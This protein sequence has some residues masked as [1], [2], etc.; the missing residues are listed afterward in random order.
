[1]AGTNR[2]KHV[3]HDGPVVILVEPQLMENVGAAARAMANFGLSEM[4]I[5]NPRE[6]FPSETATTFAAGAG[7]VLEAARV[8]ATVE[9]AISDLGFI[10]AATARERGQAK[11]VAGPEAVMRDAAAAIA[12]GARAGIMFG[13]ER[14]GL[15]NAE[16][17]LADVIM[18]FAVNPAYASLN[19]AQA[20]LLAGSVWW[21]QKI[22]GALPFSMPEK[23][24]PASRAE[25]LNFFAHLEGELDEA[26]FFRSAEKR[27]SM[28]INLRNIFQRM[29]LS[30]QDLNTLHGVVASLVKG[31]RDRTHRRERNIL[32]P[33]DIPPDET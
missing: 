10:A 3:S 18:T 33:L 25:L 13:R 30:Q 12:T 11:P 6:T 5:V 29:P 28:T 23:S 7:Y 32:K 27:H 22:A 17:A 15:H 14:A 19:L 16:V 21:N 20:V 24:P 9:E 31:R 1:M 8:F 26:G 4:R 2:S